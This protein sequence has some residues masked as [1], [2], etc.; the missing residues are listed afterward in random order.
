MAGPY[1]P[2]ALDFSRTCHAVFRARWVIYALPG[3]RHRLGF[4]VAAYD[5]SGSGDRAVGTV[6]KG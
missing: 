5:L 4:E 2:C 1:G 3:T 6:L